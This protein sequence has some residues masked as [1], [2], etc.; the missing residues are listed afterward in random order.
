MIGLEC[1]M[2]M[3]YAPEV[4]DLDVCY[5]QLPI[6]LC[7]PPVSIIQPQLNTEDRIRDS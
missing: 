2:K 6:F 7:E 4:G 5:L 3:G 1:V